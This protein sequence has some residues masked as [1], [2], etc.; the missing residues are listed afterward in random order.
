[1]RLI[2]LLACF[3]FGCA[4]TPP[5]PPMPEGDYRPINKPKTQ[6]MNTDVYSSEGIQ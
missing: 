5:K 6:S 1:M 3:L 4:G 2:I